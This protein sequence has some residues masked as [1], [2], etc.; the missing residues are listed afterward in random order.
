MLL[1]LS[2]GAAAVGDAVVARHRAQSVADLTALAAAS[3]QVRGE[4]GCAA[5]R[6]HAEAAGAALARCRAR[7]G[8]VVAVSVAL[9]P[10]RVLRRFG[11]GAVFGLARAGPAGPG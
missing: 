6:V 11:V 9:P 10:G 5:A 8:G 2:L 1:A 3:A 4:D 7:P